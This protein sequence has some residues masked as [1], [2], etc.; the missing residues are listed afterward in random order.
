MKNY[1]LILS[2]ISV[3]LIGACAQQPAQPAAQPTTQPTAVIEPALDPE[4]EPDAP[5]QEPVQIEAPTSEVVEIDMIARKWDFD[6]STITV[7]EGDKVKLNIRSVDVTHG[8]SLFEF[9][10]NERL[11]PGTTTT[12]EFTADRVGSFEYY[13]SVGAH[14]ALGMKGTL[15]VE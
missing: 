8:F 2:I 6:P 9:G 5:S 15:I 7:N 14:R 11:T 1:I 10:V 12:V 13:C 4:S 3:F